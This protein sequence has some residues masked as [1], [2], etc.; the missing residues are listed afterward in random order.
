MPLEPRGA[1]GGTQGRLSS[2]R[3]L[4]RDGSR[5]GR[6]RRADLNARQI[7]DALGIAGSMAG[8]II[9]Y[10]AEGAWTKRLHAGW[11]AQSG[12]R[13]V[14]LARGGFVGPRT[15][16]E[17]VHG[18]FHGFAHTSH[19][20]YDA[21]FGRFRHP[22]GD[23][24][25]GVQ[26]LSL[27]DDGAALYRL[28]QRLAARGIKPEDVKEIVCEVAEGT[29]HRLWEPLADKQRPRNGYAA[30]F[31]TPYLLAAGFVHGGVGLGAFTESAIR[32]ERVLALAAKVKFVIDPDNPYPN[33]YTGHI[34]ATLKDGSVI[35][36]RQPHLR[37]GAQEPL[38]RQD[39]TDKFTL[40]A[41]HG[42]WSKARSDAA[43]KLMAELYNGRIDLSS[44]RG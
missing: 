35:E 21:L 39:V 40:N 34:R 15:V 19:G 36:E 7:V 2:D 6:R 29:V 44:L 41:A 43:L 20:D 24:Y 14:L 16:F 9:E 32:D 23:G 1:E 38:T 3:D 10:L 31:A 13:A 18:L 8:G 11:A 4:R 28:R 42:G 30:K 17:G 37:G 26:A 5:R 25:A 33:N 27:R 22:L 12:I